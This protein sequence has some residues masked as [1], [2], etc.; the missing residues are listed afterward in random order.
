MTRLALF[1][2]HP[3]W[4]RPLFAELDRRGLDYL[5]IP[6][7]GHAFD[8]AG[9][10]PPAPL[11]F[12]RVAM[13]SF[14]R[15]PDHPIFYA[16]ALMAHWRGAGART[17]NGGA[18]MAIDASKARQLSLIAGLGFAVPATRIVHRRADIV[19]AAS[20]MCFPL[21]VKANI[22]GSGAG[23]V[24]YDTAEQLRE[25]AAENM[26]PDSIDRVWLIQD[27]VPARDGAITRIETLAGRYLYALDIA[28]A[29]EFDLC[30]ADVCLAGKPH[31]AVKRA[32]PPPALI[33]AA[34]RIAAAAGLDIGGIEMMT[35]DR[36][37][38]PRFYDINAFSNFVADPLDVLGWDPHA[39]LVDWLE[40]MMHEAA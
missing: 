40:T 14:L 7:D 15:A 20:G 8:P 18:V 11:I 1:Y 9:S 37:G 27:Y 17:I 13:S 36:D 34:E 38:A 33:A 3:E 29:G 4:L 30:P 31:I 5:A 2:E 22:G 19:A 24:R 28:G 21:V 26:L 25:M 23:I 12:N 10:P 39:N 6:A 35:D 16:Q 32:D